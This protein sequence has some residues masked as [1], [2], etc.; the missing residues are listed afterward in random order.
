MNQLWHSRS[1]IMPKYQSNAL[2]K[3]NM[4][5]NKPKM[6]KKKKLKK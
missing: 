3:M 6:K 1:L 5:Q 2:K 4:K